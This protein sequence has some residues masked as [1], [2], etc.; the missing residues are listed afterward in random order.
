MIVWSY[1]NID[2]IQGVIGYGNAS[3]GIT[4]WR[5]SN[6]SNGNGTFNILNSSSESS[7]FTIIDN[8]N[9]GIGT[10]PTSTS[11]LLEIGGD[12]NINGN[13]KKNN[14][15][16][17]QSSSNY[18][19]T[20]SNIL[21]NRI[22]NEV[23]FG[24]NYTDFI[25]TSLNTKINDTSN[26][27]SNILV[28]RINSQWTSTS[29]GIY[30]NKP[31]SNS[32]IF[33]QE[34]GILTTEIETVNV[35]QFT[36]TTETAGTGTGQT[37]YT[38]NVPTGGMVCDILVVGGGGGGA[39]RM[40]GGGGAGALIYDE[41]ITL[42][43]GNYI[44][45]VGN[46]GTGDTRAGNIG[47]STNTLANKRANNGSNSELYFQNTSSTP[48]Y[49]AIGGGGGLGGNT[50][51][52]AFPNEFSP[53]NGGSGGGNGGKDNG[54]GGLLSTLNIVNGTLVSV[55]NNNV[56]DSVNPS[57]LGGKCFGNKAGRGGGDNP[58]LG[59]GG[60]GAGTKGTDVN[61]VAA[62]NLVENNSGGVGGTGKVINITG[63][64]ITYAG[65]GGGG[66]FG[67][68]VSAGVDTG[69]STYYN[70]GGVGGGGRSGTMTVAPAKGTDGLGGGGGG[71]GPDMF[72]GA[73]G[74]S[75]IVIIRYYTIGTRTL[76]NTISSTPI[77]TP[78]LSVIT[79]ISKG[80]IGTD[81]YI[82]FTYT[83][84]TAG[85]GTGQTQYT[86]N[87]QEDNIV[88]D[89]LMVGGGGA[90]GIDI[91]GGGGGGAVLYGT[92]ISIPN[93]TYVLK[94]GR[95]AIPGEA[96]GKST[97][98]FGNTIIGGGSASN[99]AW[100]YP[101]TEGY[102]NPGGSGGGGKGVQIGY[103]PPTAGGVVVSTIGTIFASSTTIYNGNIGGTGTVQATIGTK[104]GAGG[105]GGATASGN[106][107]DLGTGRGG[108]GGGGVQINILETPYWWGAGGGGATEG[109]NNTVTGGNGGK[110]GGGAGEAGI[111]S[112]DIGSSVITTQTYKY[113]IFRYTTD[114]VANSG[115]TQ[116]TINVPTGGVPCDILVVGGGG[117]GDQIYGGG[118]GGGA[119][120]YATN[121]TIPA[122]TY[123]I[124]VGK[125]GAQNVNGSSSEAFGATCLGGGST[126]YVAWNTPN[127]GT[128]GGSGS[129]GSPGSWSQS[130]TGVGGS[131]GVSTKGTLLNLGTL[132]GNIG[133][134]GLPQIQ[135]TGAV[136]GGGGG[137]AG[138]VGL[139]SSQTQYTTRSSWITA[140][141][142]SSGGNGIQN[143]ITGTNYYWGAGGGGGGGSTHAGDGGLGGGGGGGMTSSI[144]GLSG[145][146]GISN[147]VDGNISGTYKTTNG[148][149]GAPNSGS[150]GGGGGDGGLG[151]AGGSGIVI[152]RY[153]SSYTITLVSGDLT[154]IT[155]SL[156]I[157]GK[158]GTNGY[159]LASGKHAGASTGSGG[160]GARYSDTV[161]GKGG[162][163]IIIIR[164]RKISTT[165]IQAANVGIGTTNPK[166]KLHIYDD[167][168]NN[169][170]VT[171]QNNYIDPIVITP[172]TG[173]TIVETIENNKYYK[174][175][176]FTYNVSYPVLSA[177]VNYLYAWYKLD[178]NLKDSSRAPYA[179][180]IE[181]GKNA[182]SPNG[183][184]TYTTD[185]TKFSNEPNYQS[186]VFNGTPT[187]NGAYILTQD[188]T[189]NVP[190]SFT[191][192]FRT[193]GTGY[194]T[195]MAYGNKT[196]ATPKISFDFLFDSG[197]S[198]YKLVVYTA[199]NNTWTIQPTV[200]GLSL[201]TWYFCVYTLSGASTVNCVLYI[202]GVNKATGNG[203]AG[204]TLSVN[205]DLTIG[206]SGD[207]SRGFVGQIANVKLY[208]KA[209]TQNEINTLYNVNIPVFILSTINFRKSTTIFVN[210]GTA[211]TV[212]GLYNISVGPVNSSVLPA[213]GQTVIPLP[214]TATTTVSIKYEYKDDTLSLPKLINVPGTITTTIG[215]TDRCISFPY[216][217]ETILNS[218][219]TQYK[220]SPTEQIECD[221]LLVG[222]GGAGGSA[223]AP[224]GGGDVLEF[225]NITLNAGSYN[226]L[227]GKGALVVWNNQYT[228]DVGKNTSITINN[229]IIEA[230]G[231]GGGGAYG[232]S[233]GWNNSRAP[234]AIPTTTFLHPI[235]FISTTS[236]GG[237]GAGAGKDSFAG[238]IGTGI[239]GNG[240]K[241]VTSDEGTAGAAGGAAPPPLGNGQDTIPASAITGNG[242]RGI[243][244]YITGVLVEYG[245]GGAAGKW[246]GP[247]TNAIQG[248]ATGGGGY[249][250]WDISA[251]NWA[252][253]DFPGEDGKGG[254]GTQSSRGGS[255]IVIIRYR[256]KKSYSS[257]ELI[258]QPYNYSSF[259]SELVITNT[260]STI[261]D[262]DYGTDRCI[263]FPYTTTSSGLTGQ[264]GYTLTT[265]EPLNC[266]ILIIGGGGGG[267][268][269][270]AGNYECGGGGAGAYLYLQNI[271]LNGTYTINVGD[272]GAGSTKGNT[273]EIKIGSTILYS[274]EGGGFGGQ[275]NGNTSSGGSGG[276]GLWGYNTFGTANDPTK[277]FD[278][279]PGTTNNGTNEGGGGGGAGGPGIL[280]DGGAGKQNNITG[281]VV[282]YAGGGGGCGTGASAGPG[283]GGSGIGGNGVS[284]ILN[285]TDGK[286][287]TGSGG[288]GSGYTRGAG[289]KGGSGVVIIRY[290]RATD[291]RI[292]NYNSAKPNY[293][294][295]NYNGDFKIIAGT[296]NN[297]T[298]YMR[299]ANYGASIYNATGSPLWSTVSDKRIKENIE[300]ASYE[301]CYDNIKKL[302]LYRFNYIS[303]LNNINKDL[304]Q[305]GYIAQEVN[306]L[307]P[308][309]VSSQTLYNNSLSISDLLSIDLTQINYTL[310]GSV[311]RLIQL[312]NDKMQRLE[313]L[314]N[315]IN[316][317]TTSNLLLEEFRD[318]SLSVTS[319]NLT[320]E[321]VRDI[322]LEAN[323]S[324]LT[325]EEISDISLSGTSSN[326]TVEEL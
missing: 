159:S 162:S 27:A 45:R 73:N 268:T 311:K 207:A 316:N 235:T 64:N 307:F 179:H 133:G 267:G 301:K 152:I 249:Q 257:I 75:G 17:M 92:N 315:I 180:N 63:S 193:N 6:T 205:R 111:G 52:G 291:K 284:N 182:T 262:T 282:S 62:G 71:D 115:Q 109:I 126:S 279:A 200:T 50:G 81:R 56:S 100:G 165:S 132:Y 48:I 209:L 194:Y 294:I 196:A 210:G 293:R 25:N 297:Q 103:T 118:G 295:G 242:G 313:K 36:Y 218:G 57:Y 35:M 128:T 274:C 256:K 106:N 302:E 292:G 275:S 236:Q 151:G 120:L 94:V 216:T 15:D 43:T 131:V 247:Y 130:V 283:L 20:T 273:T 160:G 230:A 74:G 44:I 214:L 176:T 70:E 136:C 69:G 246:N 104:V 122:A 12:L 168:T 84:E 124:K 244:S 263:L 116:Y 61:I 299:I 261:I 33:P 19:N 187:S 197:T 139:N 259:V 4:D 241:S 184:I 145:T 7:R 114:T 96:K 82:I 13:Y 173:H 143:N 181:G 203:N 192:W 147:G 144:A 304:K 278:G 287:N 281:S 141:K 252:K 149:N 49:R 113:M 234:S 253:N 303:E 309:S 171:I 134:N 1:S 324:N 227:V 32:I 29:S 137:G 318:I 310:F 23:R 312:I 237:G 272:G 325:V 54:A 105:G 178:G 164:Y 26:Y 213:E 183:A 142:P 58:W 51:S 41:N 285:A 66:T 83:T 288:G 3:E 321:E 172:N 191:F 298:E 77:I 161:G 140:G 277:G 266:E 190:I 222:G 89:I 225:N 305:L 76:Q 39:R 108:D 42:G 320:V 286:K 85:I 186:A 195:I 38:I 125:G 265:I 238:A 239:S 167:T 264:T 240:G 129:G 146:G 60:G 155:F 97:E 53:L 170:S 260:I 21:V 243:S 175:L 202:N 224:G 59:S 208:N 40:G 296:A 107:A 204:Q 185:S 14:I 177:D 67:Y 289:G 78:T 314:E 79:G 30:Y 101:N 11:S 65:G 206:A 254:G 46:G 306:E 154:G 34:L 148:G 276:G 135:A 98:G 323:T 93:G 37:Q 258:R 217:S 86:I 212:T 10:T 231:G 188:I 229:N 31:I 198:S 99:T 322:S 72:S 211:I 22:V 95:G 87:V 251:T 127:N 219:Q 117:G 156:T 5:I 119:V 226:I 88:Y 270:G 2:I 199:L 123:T 55:I 163:G 150:G 215:T 220:F 90:G 68:T 223:G 308:K 91:G 317:S 248:T 8:G 201:N 290:R 9:I 28:N 157:N 110:G 280:K 16:I 121:V 158:E 112:G 319:S 169:T 271:N 153:L 189:R 233:G 300:R 166:S 102:G 232:Y 18:I 228:A 221:I 174:T 255:G 47:A 138:S 245:G 80:I 24:S 250:F 326:L 269:W